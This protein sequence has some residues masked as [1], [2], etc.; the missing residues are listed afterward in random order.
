MQGRVDAGILNG[1]V[2]V[3]HFLSARACQAQLF[4][5]SSK[6]CPCSSSS[7]C[8]LPQNSEQPL[9]YLCASPRRD[10]RPLCPLPPH[11]R[12]NRPLCWLL[13]LLAR[14]GRLLKGLGQ[15]IQGCAGHRGRC[16]LG[17]VSGLHDRLR[18]CQAP[19]LWHRPSRRDSK[20]GERD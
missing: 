18:P 2:L 19:G 7:C 10:P 12:H 16:G 1:R 4:Q 17:D 3:H 14:A 9:A 20:H 13:C 8:E 6:L 15:G 5:L 11:Q